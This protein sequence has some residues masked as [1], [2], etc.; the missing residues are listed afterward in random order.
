M[1]VLRRILAWLGPAWFSALA[2]GAIA[3]FFLALTGAPW[4]FVVVI[5]AFYGLIAG[6][7]EESRR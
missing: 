6:A 3:F 2:C 1:T 4:P 5:A 7:I